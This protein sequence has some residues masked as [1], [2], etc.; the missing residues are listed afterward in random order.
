MTTTLPAAL[1]TPTD[2][3]NLPIDYVPYNAWSVY[4][5][6]AVSFFVFVLFLPP[7]LYAIASGNY[8]NTLSA[9]LWRIGDVVAS[10]PPWRWAP[11]HWALAIIV[12]GLFGWLILHFT[13]GILR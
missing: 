5:L 9:Q 12:V 13:F 6:S 2:P 3:A 1:P 8:Q 10:Q 7:E 4:W 11:E